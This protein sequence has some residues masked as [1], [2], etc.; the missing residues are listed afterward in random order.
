MATIVP[1]TTDAASAGQ[2]ATPVTAQERAAQRLQ[3]WAAGH[4]DAAALATLASLAV[5]IDS[6]LLRRLRLQL[7][8][9]AEPGIE[10]DVWFSGLHESRGRDGL[11]LDAQVQQQLRAR[12]AQLPAGD[13]G[14]RPLE[15][16]WQITAALHADAPEALQ[17]EQAL[18]IEALR[19]GDGL[20][21]RI[22]SLLAP[23]LAAMAG[24][25]DARALEVA[26]S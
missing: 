3:A 11:V 22:D 20:A 17:A 18:T 14:M 7:L 26:V 24:G 8:P 10:A 16:A 15:R 12:L 13:D 6:A 23:A 5:R 25:G 9:R 4:P 21:A 1:P 2:A 19:G